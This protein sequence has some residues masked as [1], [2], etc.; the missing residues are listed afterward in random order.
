LAGRVQPARDRA[1]DRSD[2]V[3]DVA[4]AADRRA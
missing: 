4:H 2:P 1:A 3:D